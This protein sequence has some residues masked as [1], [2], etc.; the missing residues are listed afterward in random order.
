MLFIKTSAVFC[1]KSKTWVNFLKRRSADSAKRATYSNVPGKRRM[2]F[3]AYHVCC[4][5]GIAPPST[6]VAGRSHP[7]ARRSYPHQPLGPG[8]PPAGLAV[9]GDGTRPMSRPR[10]TP[11]RLSAGAHG[12]ERPRWA[13]RRGL[14]CAGREARAVRMQQLLG[15]GEQTPRDANIR[16]LCRFQRSIFARCVPRARQ[17]AAGGQTHRRR[18]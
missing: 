9:L 2:G 14:C 12:S 18:K 6:K 8:R 4:E 16:F 15:R 5:F 3:R 10:R 7:S 1:S 13:P 11:P 17:V